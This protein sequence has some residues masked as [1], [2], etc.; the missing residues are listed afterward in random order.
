MKLNEV[1]FGDCLELMKLIPDKSIDFICCD[2]PYGTTKCSWDSLINLDK[3]W[4]QYERIIKDNGCIALFSQTP[5]DKVLGYS[6][7]PLLRYEWIWEKT[8][9]TGHLNAKKMPMK[10]HENILI[11]YKKLPVYNPIKTYGHVR[12][13]SKAEHKLHCKESDIYNKGQKLT[14]YDS[15]E[16]YPRDIQKFKSDK[17]TVNLYPTQK[18][19]ELI[20]YF[21]KTYTDENMVVLDNCCGSGTTGVACKNTNRNYILMDN[22]P[23]A[24]NISIK[25]LRNDD[26][27]GNN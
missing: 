17:Q 2:L 1:Y 14:T 9:A 23:D 7:L 21:I 22:S 27:E 10:A 8:S 3:L 20:E 4:V 12:K 19:V 5:F 6:N 16:R 15:S 25:R 26:K 18:P 24:I 13:T 11:F